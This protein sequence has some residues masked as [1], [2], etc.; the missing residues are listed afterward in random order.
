MGAPNFTILEKLEH[1]ART[2]PDKAAV[3]YEPGES[4]SHSEL[5]ALSGKI[6]AYLKQ[7]GIGA[8]DV[9]MYCL[10]RGLNL[11]AS[12]IGTMRA[13]AAFVLTETDNSVQRT[14]FIKKDCECRLFVDEQLFQ[15]ILETEPA[16]RF[17]PENMHSLCYIAYTS[18]TTGSPKGV[19][20][21]YG[22]LENACKAAR[23]KDEPLFEPQNIFL[24]MS[25]MNF[26]SFPIAFALS[27]AYEFT[28]AVMPYHYAESE[29]NLLDY[30]EQNHVD[31]GYITPSF[32]R[33]HSTLKLPW[34]KCILSSESA[35]GIFLEGAGN[36]NCYASTEAGCLLTVYKLPHA[37][38]PAPV[39]YPKSDIDLSVIKED[40]TKA[41][42]NEEGEVCFA[43]PYIRGYLHLP[44]ETKRLMDGGVIHTGNAGKMTK[45]GLVICGRMT[46]MFK[47]Q[48]FRIEPEEVEKAVAEVCGIDSP[49]VR[50]FVHKDISSI[51]VFYTGSADIDVVAAREKLQKRLPEYMVPT[52]FIRVDH[53]PLLETG[54]LDRHHLLPKEGDWNEILKD[55]LDK[56]R[57][58]KFPVVGK[59]RTSTVLQIS[60]DKVIKL[61]HASIPFATI[62]GEYERTRFVHSAKIPAPDAYDVV[63][64]R[65]RYGIIL[66]YVQGENLEQAILEHPNR[67]SE[68]LKKFVEAVKEIHQIKICDSSIPDIKKSAISFAKNL[69]RQKFSDSDVEKIINIFRCIPDSKGF[70]H[71]DC[72]TANAMVVGNKISFIDF[73]LCGKGHPVFDLVCM[74]SHYVFL[75]SFEEDQSYRERT[76]FSK[77]D[78][79]WIFEEFFRYYYNT[80]DAQF[81]EETK[82]QLLGI[83]A[84]RLCLA[85]IIIP[86]SFSEWILQSVKKIAVDFSDKFC[87]P[88]SIN[89][90]CEL[91]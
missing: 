78:A 89:N 49:V 34:K 74:Y 53:F 26:V 71:G 39:G 87:R 91:C 1:L 70:V 84:A 83:L 69:D 54:K 56:D 25:P 64:S 75:P 57:M 79:E 51:V 50:G 3:F 55:C 15:E 36:Y 59:G 72:H 38:T 58:A 29:D 73:S 88:G 16:E 27:V 82:K 4:L 43:S 90:I 80:D 32:V 18:G 31:C 52:N 68:L 11:F 19:L 65:K 12:I 48:G 37:M 45:D 21:E 67:R 76:G 86:D 63:L 81:L 17:V 44:G 41:L 62:Q 14:A 77:K 35:D 33:K 40:G 5:W 7:K 13:G 28:I 61:F 46:E 24:L 22:S 66:D 42:E 47:E 30:I 9:I 85:S 2:A 6:Y 60:K 20:H 10:P 8:E 23:H